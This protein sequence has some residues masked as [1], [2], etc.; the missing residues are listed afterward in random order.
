MKHKINATRVK[1]TPNHFTLETEYEYII[2]MPKYLQLAMKWKL[3]INTANMR[4]S[5]DAIHDYLRG[6]SLGRLVINEISFKDGRIVVTLTVFNAT[7]N[8]ATENEFKKRVNDIYIRERTEYR[9][10][11]IEYITKNNIK[12]H[13][14]R[15]V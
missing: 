11:F 6:A 12:Y 14:S 9:K 1:G 13:I 15:K 4:K 5:L 10:L 2:K 8:V 7:Y 3:P